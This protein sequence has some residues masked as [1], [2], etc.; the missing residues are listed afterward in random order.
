MDN[1]IILSNNYGWGWGGVGGWVGGGWVCG[2]VGGLVVE[3]VR[4]GAAPPPLILPPKAPPPPVPF[5]DPH[6]LI[7]TPRP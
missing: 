4:G 6:T 2:C 5:P 1:S 7:R 3:D